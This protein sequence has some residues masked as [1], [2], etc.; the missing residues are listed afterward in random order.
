[1]ASIVQ[2]AGL[3][4]GDDSGRTRV[5]KEGEKRDLEG[6]PGWAETVVEQLGSGWR[7]LEVG[8]SCGGGKGAR[9]RRALELRAETAL[10][11]LPP[12]WSNCSPPPKMAEATSG[13]SLAEPYSAPTPGAHTPPSPSELPAE[14]LGLYGDLWEETMK[15]ALRINLTELETARERIVELEKQI[16]AGKDGAGASTGEGDAATG[17]G[18]RLPL[19]FDFI[20]NRSEAFEILG[21]PET[22]SVDEIEQRFVR[23]SWCSLPARELT[24]WIQLQKP[25]ELDDVLGTFTRRER[26]AVLAIASRR[27][28]RLLLSWIQRVLYCEA[29]VHFSLLE[30]P[31]FIEAA[32]LRLEYPLSLFHDPTD[33][34]FISNEADAFAALRISP[35]SYEAEIYS[36]Y[37]VRYHP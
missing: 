32:P 7:Q 28:P 16:A 36:A 10:A 34:T 24:R 22:S 6:P 8:G 15:A 4:R 11:L 20:N 23:R 29:T 1:M 2:R 3:G 12:T 9:R 18:A 35:S 37:K 19:T 14:V 30:L 5:R 27:L 21:L 33:F 25:T 13:P 17:S 26:G 31:E